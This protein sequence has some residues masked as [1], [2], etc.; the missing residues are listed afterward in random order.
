M[1]YQGRLTRWNDAKG[2]GFVSPN[3]GGEKAFV[4]ISAFTDRQR[5]KEGVIITYDL[6]RDKQNRLQAIG[7]R[8]PKASRP[9]NI[10]TSNGLVAYM[11]A[12]LFIGVVVILVVLEMLP[13]NLLFVYLIA[14]GITFMVYAFDK[15]AAMRNEWR[16]AENTMHLLSLI[17][18][19]P[20]ALVGQQLFRHK[21]KKLEF[22]L[23]Y[24]C[25]IIANCALLAWLTTEQGRSFLEKY[26]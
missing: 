7:I 21:T 24:W 4:H 23:M 26:G 1:R 25:S 17:G 14:S 15:A 22:Q 8:Y 20:G 9:T 10:P 6:G 13:I 18:G 12:A 11:A 2:Y 19:W 3:G 5:P 16:T